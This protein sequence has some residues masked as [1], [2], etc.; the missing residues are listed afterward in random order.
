M[1]IGPG[2]APKVKLSAI[3][4]PKKRQCALEELSI[5]WG[6]TPGVK[7]VVSKPS[8]RGT[9]EAFFPAIVEKRTDAR[10]VER[11]F[12]AKTIGAG[13]TTRKRTELSVKRV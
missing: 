9:P 6:I 7:N 13:E 11:Y 5:V 3:T 12:G 8:S 1:T 10:T 4:E 2:L